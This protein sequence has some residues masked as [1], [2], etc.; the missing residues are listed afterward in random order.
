MLR[1]SP[2]TAEMGLMNPLDWQTTCHSRRRKTGHAVDDGGHSVG[3]SRR[4]HRHGIADPRA[5]AM[6]YMDSVGTKHAFHR[7]NVIY[8]MKWTDL[9]EMVADAAKPDEYGHRE[10]IISW[11]RAKPHWF[12][13]MM[14]DGLMGSRDQEI[15]WMKTMGFFQHC[16]PRLHDNLDE[17]RS[18]RACLKCSNSRAVASALSLTT[19]G[20]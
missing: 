17:A 4:T 19:Q 10:L 6:L 1:S 13:W 9:A 14:N 16:A 2:L 20:S 12:A 11:R 3:V 18:V 8:W 7:Q 5:L 15:K